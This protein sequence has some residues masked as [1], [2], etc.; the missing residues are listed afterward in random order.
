MVF[1]HRQKPQKFQ[2]LLMKSNVEQICSMPKKKESEG[3]R[4]STNDSRGTTDEISTEI[5]KET[6]ESGALVPNAPDNEAN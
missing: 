5:L 4:E 2:I 3:S 1:F 6:S